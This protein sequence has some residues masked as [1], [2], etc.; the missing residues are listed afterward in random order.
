MSKFQIPIMILA[1]IAIIYSQYQ[2]EYKL[3]ILIPSIVIFMMG[4]M[5]LSSKIPGKN[6]DKEDEHV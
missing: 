3:I 6:Q 4:M 5:N 2:P 1:V